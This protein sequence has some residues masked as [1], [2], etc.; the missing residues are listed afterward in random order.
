MKPSE[1]RPHWLG[2]VRVDL[3]SVLGKLD[4]I[5]HCIF[6][7]LQRCYGKG[8]DV[9]YSCCKVAPMV[10]LILLLH[11]LGTLWLLILFFRIKVLLLVCAVTRCWFYIRLSKI[12]TP[13]LTSPGICYCITLWNLLIILNP[14]GV[15]YLL[16]LFDQ[17]FDSKWKVLVIIIFFFDSLHPLPDQIDLLLQ[18]LL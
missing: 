7:L 4:V 15:L 18:W 3:R 11:H 5:F 17:K 2:L 13:N 14:I 16:F 8:G 10:I 1:H 12:W 9:C 6:V